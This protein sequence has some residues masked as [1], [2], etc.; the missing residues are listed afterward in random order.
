VKTLG[1][2]TILVFCLSTFTSCEQCVTCVASYITTNELIESQ[3]FCGTKKEVND[4]ETQ[5]LNS[6]IDSVF[7]IECVRDK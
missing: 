7:T 1:Q 2:L 4:W 6:E 3:E 5:V